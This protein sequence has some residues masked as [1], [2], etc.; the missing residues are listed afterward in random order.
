MSA[1]D[2][3][4]PV[5]VVTGG[6]GGIGLAS[7]RR[8]A[9]GHALLLADLSRERLDDAVRELR[10]D[11]AS[12]EGVIC[13]VADDGA[14][15]ALA[16][17]AERLG[18]LRALVHTAGLSSSMGSAQRILDVN[19]RGTALVLDAFLPQATPGTVAVGV[20]SIAAHRI[21]PAAFDRLLADAGDPR[22]LDRL[23][24]AG[25]IDD[26]PG[27]AYDLSKRGVVLACEL[28]AEAWGR[29]GARIVSVSPGLVD[30]AMGRRAADGGRGARLAAVAAVGRMGDAGEIG[31]A[32]AWLCSGAASYVTGCD[33]RVDGGVVAGVRHTAPPD[34][35]A[36]WNGWDWTPDRP[37]AR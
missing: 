35:A 15:G 10:D 17:A 8:L 34:V 32:I 14:V 7:A 28:R 27:R 13:D 20:A 29:R 25:A 19:L 26:E 37:P 36:G 1:G 24:E 5:A 18:P 11:G 6:A 2:D 9:P 33:L 30:T 21:G 3:A 23:R 12:A 16:A 4:R 31:D 22:L